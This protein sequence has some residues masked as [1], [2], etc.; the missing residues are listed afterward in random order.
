MYAAIGQEGGHFFLLVIMIKP[1]VLDK[2][3]TTELVT[4]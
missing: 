2:G 1:K 3:C 4:D